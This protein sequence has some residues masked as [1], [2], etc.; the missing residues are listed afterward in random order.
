[1]LHHS[2]MLIWCFIITG[3]KLIMVFCYQFWKLNIFVET[4]DELELKKQIQVF[5][6]IRMI[7]EGSC[8]TEDWR[9]NDC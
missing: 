8:D 2:N 1:V 9:L 4:F 5:Y 7:S 6:V 3:V